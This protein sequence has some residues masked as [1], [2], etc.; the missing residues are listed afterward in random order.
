VT[1]PIK[2]DRELETTIKRIASM[3]EQLSHLRKVE[4]NPANYHASASGFIAEMD[5][6]Q[7]A[8]REY[9]STHPTEWASG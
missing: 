6:M 4:S 8:V 9:L 1:T 2:T 7:L 3:Q 5:R